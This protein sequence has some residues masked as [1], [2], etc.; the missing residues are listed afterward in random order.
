DANATANQPGV[1]QDQVLQSAEWLV[2]G[3]A[4]GSENFQRLFSLTQPAAGRE[5]NRLGP[6][7]HQVEQRLLGVDG[8]GQ[9]R[10]DGHR[11]FESLATLLPDEGVKDQRVTDKELV[12]KFLDQRPACVSPAPP[13]KATER[14]AGTIVAQRDKLVRLADRGGQRHSAL[15]ILAAAGQRDRRQRITLRQDEQRL[16]Q[17]PMDKPAKQS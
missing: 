12:L 8:A 15:L 11:F 9:R 3:A 2:T 5:A 16:W 7:E 6:D 4:H 13:V 14:V 17:R 10:G 1:F